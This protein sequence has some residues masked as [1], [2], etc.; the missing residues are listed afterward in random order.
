MLRPTKSLQRSGGSHPEYVS[1]HSGQ[2]AASLGTLEAL[3]G[4]NVPFVDH[5]HV[6]DGFAPLALS[7]RR[8]P[9]AAIVAVIAAKR[10]ERFLPND[11]HHAQRGHGIGPPPAEKRIQQQTSQ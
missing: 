4:S 5:A 8:T 6:A 1:A 11:W 10:F 7:H 9:S 2:S 3:F